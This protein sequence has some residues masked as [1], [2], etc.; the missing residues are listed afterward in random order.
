MPLLNTADM[1]RL[2]DNRADR[3]MLGTTKLWERYTFDF[4]RAST[5][6]LDGVEHAAH[7]PRFPDGDSILIEEGTTNILPSS[8]AN[9]TGSSTFGASN[10]AETSDEQAWTGEFSRKCIYQDD[11]RIWGSTGRTV[12]NDAWY[13]VSLRV[14]IPADFDA[15]ALNL[16]PTDAITG[17]M[18]S[19]DMSLRDQWQTLTGTGQA[20]STNLNLSL[21]HGS[22]A[23]TAGRF[24]Y[25]D[26]VQLERK[27]YAT[28]WHPGG[29]T[30]VYDDT[31]LPASIA[32]PS[33]GTLEADIFINTLGHNLQ[34]ILDLG[35]TNSNGAVFWARE[36]GALAF[37]SAGNIA[38]GGSG[39]AVSPPALT[40]LTWHRVFLRWDGLNISLGVNG[41]V[42]DS[43][44]L[45][46][47]LSFYGDN[48][49]LGW[50]NSSRTLNGLF[51]GVRISDRA[52]TDAELADWQA[53]LDRDTDTTYRITTV[54]LADHLA[55]S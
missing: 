28:S 35:G 24:I 8:H 44:S 4:T 5:A 51:G 12:V 3:V 53:P 15:D 22:T 46:N 18:A 1:V 11:I 49:R 23:P 27:P 54:E 9:G 36:N 6:Y 25:V 17:T 29:A 43:Y 40:A 34:A 50:S 52:R 47:P 26:G 41:V 7:V 31:R 45:L 10:T 39:T 16:V 2:G 38:P 30:R 37:Q 20:G 55:A 13:T 48:F 14:W 21:R 19:A 42:I 32:S 33:V